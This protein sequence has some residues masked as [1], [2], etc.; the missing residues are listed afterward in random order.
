MDMPYQE[1]PIQ[2]HIFLYEYIYIFIRANEERVEVQI[3]GCATV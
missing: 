3:S 1:N 2:A